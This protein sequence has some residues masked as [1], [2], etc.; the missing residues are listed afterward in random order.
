MS[1]NNDVSTTHNNLHSRAL[2]AKRALPVVG[3]DRTFRS[4]PLGARLK[5]IWSRSWSGLDLAFQFITLSLVQIKWT[6]PRISHQP[7]R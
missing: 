6:G 5:S 3:L 4:G 7:V 2:R 1:T